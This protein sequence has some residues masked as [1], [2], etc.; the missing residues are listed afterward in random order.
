VETLFKQIQDC[1]EYSEAGGVLIG[2]PQQINVGYA[3]IFTTGHFMIACHRL[4][5]TPATEKTW[6][7]FKSHIS[8]AHHQHKKMQGESASKAGYYSANVDVTQNEDQMA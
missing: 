6:T 1:A 5:E 8:A 3:K 4:N 7:P 2:H